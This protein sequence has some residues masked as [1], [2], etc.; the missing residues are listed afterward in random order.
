VR[1]FLF[2]YLTAGGLLACESADGV[3]SL[4]AEGAAMVVALATDFARIRDVQVVA[5]RDVR[6]RLPMPS[7]V[8]VRDVATVA[9]WE[10]AF[11]EEAARADWTVVIAPEID[12][13]LHSCIERV[14]NVGG[15]LLGPSGEIVRL[16][17]DKQATAEHLLRAGVPVPAGCLL[18]DIARERLSPPLVIKP[19]DGAGSQ[20]VRMLTTAD[21]NGPATNKIAGDLWRWRI[22]EFRPGLPASVAVLCGPGGPVPLVPCSQ[23]LSKDGQFR[24]MGGS[25]PLDQDMARRA[26]QLALRTVAAL[27][28]PLGNLGIDMVLAERSDGGDD[29]VIEINP[30]LTT[31]YVGLRA[32]TGDNL[33]I[34]MLD[35][36]AGRVPDLTFAGERVE[37]TSN[38]FVQ[39]PIVPI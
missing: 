31:S 20:G 1:I 25:L 10:A 29:V 18:A 7:A 14:T 23:L 17:G 6:A 8:K 12:N 32:A 3:D 21:L 33:A 39:K 26:A 37:F 36:A 2:E 9:D 27:P 38:G 11:A 28:Q 22:E 4:A 24:Y 35:V 15:R 5:L 30:R 34:A 13:A 19:R 16:T